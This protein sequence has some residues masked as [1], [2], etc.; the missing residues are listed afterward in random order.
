[1]NYQQLS[2]LLIIAGGLV[3]SAAILDFELVIHLWGGW[4]SFM[5]SVFPQVRVRYDGL[6]F[7]GVGCALCVVLIQSFM[8]WFLNATGQDSA[9]NL[10]QVRQRRR[11]KWRHSVALLTL[12]LMMFVIVTS[13]AGLTHQIGWLIRSPIAW[14]SAETQS[15]LDN[16]LS[17]YRVG[18]VDPEATGR[19]WVAAIAPYL[20]VM[21][22]NVDDSLPWNDPKNA[23]QYR[24]VCPNMF[25]PRASLPHKSP[26][27]YGLNHFAA[28]AELI[29]R[30]KPLKLSEVQ[31]SE[32]L[33][34]GEVNQAL[35]PWAMPGNCR[36]AVSGLNDVGPKP[37][38]TRVG[39]GSPTRDRVTLFGMLDGSVRGLDRDIDPVVLQQLGQAKPVRPAE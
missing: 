24:K 18:V 1:M 39:F 8:S 2:I 28:N 11:W 6:I 16:Q 9:Q 23:H 19:S 4:F 27:G 13:M 22:E 26:D 25:N 3:V 20:P 38:G 29:V 15:E 30:P 14:Y 33:L 31:M 32:T 10:D 12:L 21:I 36:S 7:F 35:V 34:V 17:E 37:A 5:A